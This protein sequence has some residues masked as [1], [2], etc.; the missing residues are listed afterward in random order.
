[1]TIKNRLEKL[2]SHLSAK[3]YT[4][5]MVEEMQKYD[6]FDQY[7]VH[8]VIGKWGQHY[9]DFEKVIDGIRAKMKGED[10]GVIGRAVLKAHK[11][12]MFLYLMLGRV[13]ASYQ[14]EHYRHAYNGLTLLHL[15]QSA[16]NKSLRQIAIKNPSLEELREGL[17]DIREILDIFKARATRHV[18]HLL[19]ERRVAEEI[20]KRFF[21]GRELMFKRE[22]DTL[23]AMTK[24]ALTIIAQAQDV[25]GN[26]MFYLDKETVG[27]VDPSPLVDIDTIR[28]EVERDLEQHVQY[29]VDM[30]RA[31]VFSHIGKLDQGRAIFEQYGNLIATG[32]KLMR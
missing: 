32:E 26:L 7:S 30:T 31:E 6:S 25:A 1:M 24:Q 19:T 29:E 14:N 8:H 28:A 22:R 2:D 16:Q 5:M 11:E 10:K 4:I 18:Y 23:E 12:G 13:I 15:W 3:Q 21:D 17:E 20:S 9:N 27:D